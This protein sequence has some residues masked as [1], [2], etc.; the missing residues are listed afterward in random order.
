VSVVELKRLQERSGTIGSNSQISQTYLI[1]TNSRDDDYFIVRE[2]IEGE[3]G[4]FLDSHPENTFYTRREI[5]VSAAS[6]LHWTASVS[7]ST[8]PIS[9]QERERND[10][11]NPIDRRA[12]IS[13]ES[14]ETQKYVTKDY[15]GTPLQN[16][17]GEPIEPLPTDF[18][19]V[20]LNIRQNIPS[21]QASWIQDF[22]NTTNENPVIMS[23][24]VL[25]LGIDQDKGLLKAMNFSS[26]QE[27][28]GFQFYEASLKIHVTHDSEYKWKTILINEGFNYL[29]GTDLIRFCQKDVDGVLLDGTGG[30]ER[31]PSSVPKKLDGAGGKLA[32]DAEPILLEFEL[33]KKADWLELPFFSE[34]T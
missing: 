29:E 18:T 21:Y 7:W 20:I 11:P 22:S 28:N 2:A 27:E 30:T 31:V 24:G 25:I 8:E 3:V 13:V 14:R 9:N 10:F 17:A 12:K 5:R 32:D 19:D 1:R 15:E 16:K 33:Y 6:P 26:L 23:D 4:G 34:P